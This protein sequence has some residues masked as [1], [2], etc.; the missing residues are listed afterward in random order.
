MILNI[1]QGSLLI[2]VFVFVMLGAQ[3]VNGTSL[4]YTY[5]YWHHMMPAPHAYVPD[6]AIYGHHLGVGSFSNPQDLFATETGFLYILDSGNHRIIQLD[7]QGALVRVIDGF[8]DGADQGTLNNPT[9]LHV[10]PEGD[11]YIA[12]RGN[13]R[14]VVLDDELHAWLI[15][16]SP[17][18]QAPEYFEADFRFR[19]V[20]ITSDDQGTIYVIATGVYDGIL[21]FD[22]QGHFLGFKGAPR[23]TPSV[24]DYIW[25]QIATDAQKERMALFLPVEHSN[26]AVDERG[27]VYATAVGEG[28]PIEER[29]RRLNTAGRDI[30]IRNLGLPPIGDFVE[31]DQAE[32]TMVDILPGDYGTYSVLD[33][34]RGRVFTYDST[35]NLLYVFGGLGNTLGT[36]RNPVAL[37]NF[38]GNMLVLD[39]L[40]NSVTVFSPTEYQRTIFA[41]LGHYDT[42]HFDDAALLWAKVLELNTNYDL[43]YTGTG[44]AHFLQG[45]YAEAMEAFR[46]ANNRTAYSEAYRF[47]RR[48]YLGDKFGIVATIVG[49]ILLVI[50]WACRPKEHKRDVGE[51]MGE[52]A[53]TYMAVK[54]WEEQEQRGLIV[55]LRRIYHGLRYALRLITS[56][57][58]GFWDL[59][60]EKRGNVPA[61]MT[62]LGL[63]VLTYV[64]MRQY[65]GFLFNTRNPKELNILLEIFSIVFPFFLWSAINWSLTTLMD[66]KGSF[67][68]IVIA[69]AYALTPIILLN[70][71]ATLLSN[72][73]TLQEGAFYHFFF[74]LSLLWALGLLFFGTMVTHDYSFGGTVFVVA[75]I[76]IGIGIA[77]FIG[78]LF[79]DILLQLFGFFVEV[80]QE[81]IFR[82]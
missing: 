29:I 6:R 63:V 12:D 32:S 19:P 72:F 78:M 34:V 16:E 81:L 20:K 27:F 56:P 42:G 71:P 79:V 11:L 48:D 69:T 8:V 59:K 47:Y 2:I 77:L 51:A 10:S 44:N 31:A 14:I 50:M 60:H 74:Y 3:V 73:L 70:L 75:C 28:L 61:A 54:A 33:R 22:A 43:A 82:L 23:V 64:I 52:V 41:A 55:N 65:T 5:N 62:I 1:R 36:F 26:L 35:G 49:G 46:L 30:L 45:E 76:I 17:A 53:A 80:Y 68:D 57:F 67:A 9:G 21:E 4:S 24:I 15:I 25:R 18:I 37:A 39:S 40:K 38:D 58:E 13:G 66:G 7:S